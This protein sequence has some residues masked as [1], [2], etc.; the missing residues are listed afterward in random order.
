[1]KHSFTDEQ[2]NEALSAATRNNRGISIESFSDETEWHQDE[3]QDLRAILDA[4]PE[5]ETDDWQPCTID[6]IRKGD[7]FKVEGRGWHYESTATH[8]DIDVVCV[9]PRTGSFIT[10]DEVDQIDEITLYRIPAPVVH[11]DPEVHEF[12]FTDGMVWRANKVRTTYHCH[13]QMMRPEWITDWTPGKVVEDD[14]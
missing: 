3:L 13:G 14:R 6:Q 9:N 10:R 5:P 8:I 12:I 4:L 1:M 2:I 11:P 7:R